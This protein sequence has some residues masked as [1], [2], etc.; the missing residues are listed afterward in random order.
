MIFDEYTFRHPI[1]DAPAIEAQSRVEAIQGKRNTWFCGAYLRHGF[2]EDG[3]ASAVGVAARLG[4][5]PP[6]CTP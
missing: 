3:L 6:W 1:F 5:H 4:A 2:H